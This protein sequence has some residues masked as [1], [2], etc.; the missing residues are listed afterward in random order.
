MTQKLQHITLEHTPVSA[1]CGHLGQIHLMFL[2]QATYSGC[3]RRYVACSLHSCSCIAI[4]AIAGARAA[5]LLL[6]FLLCLIFFCSHFKLQQ[7]FAYQ[8]QF[9][10]VME[11]SGDFAIVTTR[12]GHRCLVRLHLAEIVE[13]LDSVAHLDEPFLDGYL[14]YSLTDVT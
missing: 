9:I 7:R 1:R 4:G 3:G 8:R 14:A 5:A 6:L 12:Y 2:S 13:L 10:N 11:D